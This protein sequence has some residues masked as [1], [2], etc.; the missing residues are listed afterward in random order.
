MR[1]AS[2]SGSAVA[3]CEILQIQQLPSHHDPVEGRAESPAQSAVQ[4]GAKIRRELHNETTLRIALGYYEIGNPQWREETW[5]T[6]SKRDV[7]V[8]LELNQ[9]EDGH[10][11]LT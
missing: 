7:N 1:R 5:R 3:L 10:E 2:A 9:I 8:L 4:T 11:A 6:K